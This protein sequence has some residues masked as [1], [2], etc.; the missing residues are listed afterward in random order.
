MKRALPAVVTALI[1]SQGVPASAQGIM[2]AA[3]LRGAGGF[4]AGVGAAFAGK[5]NSTSNS[6]SALSSKLNQAARAG[7][8]PSPQSTAVNK[9][10]E[11]KYLA[12]VQMEKSGK[13]AEAAAMLAAFAAYRQ[14]L[15]GAGDNE[16]L[17]SY[18]RA[19]ALASKAGKQAD[20][21]KYRRNALAVCQRTSGSGSAQVRQRM[22]K[23]SDSS[24]AKPA[25][26]AAS[27]S[28]AP[29]I[30]ADDSNTSSTANSESA[31]APAGSSNAG[32]E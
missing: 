6:A 21:E 29:V 13:L 1:L 9:I 31:V 7:Q 26:P 12:A 19:A 24:S 18:D 3:G 17:K 32:Q 8:K 23:L 16:V 22:E 2:D 14:Q 5:K 27:T 20:A 15:Y 4:G 10:A 28:P 25:S 30:H 11:N